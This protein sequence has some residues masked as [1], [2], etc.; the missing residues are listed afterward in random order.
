MKWN[1]VIIPYLLGFFSSL[2]LSFYILEIFWEKEYVNT[3]IIWNLVY[4][5]KIFNKWIWLWIEINRILMLFLTAILILSIVYFFIKR[6]PNKNLINSLWYWF[7]TWWAL[8]NWYERFFIWE[9]FDYIAIKWLFVFNSA[10]F[11]I[12]IGIIFII[13]NEFQR[14]WND[15]DHKK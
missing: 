15:F 5:T 2:L 13:Y 11:F 1:N 14:K 9:V 3:H 12:F 7:L 10:D 8:S 6:E 4:F